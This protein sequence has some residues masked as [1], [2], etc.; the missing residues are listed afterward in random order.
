MVQRLISLTSRIAATL[1]VHKVCCLLLHNGQVSITSLH[2]QS[3]A[4]WRGRALFY[5]DKS[6]HT[7]IQPLRA[8]DILKA[9]VQETCFHHCER[10]RCI[11]NYHS[12]C[13]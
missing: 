5:S 6:Q 10:R 1:V 8:I 7:Q 2:P 4:G 9:F 13:S 11:H 12:R 3:T